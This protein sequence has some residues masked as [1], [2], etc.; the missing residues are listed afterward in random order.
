MFDHPAGVL[1][2]VFSVLAFHGSVYLLVALIAGWRFGYWITGAAT[3]ALLFILTAFW[4]ITALGPRGIEPHWVPVGAAQDSV[5]QVTVNDATLISTST[6]PGSTWESADSPDSPLNPE[7]DAFRSAV[8]N[9][10]DTDPDSL[11]ENQ[12]TVCA[13]AQALL[14]AEDTLPRADGLAVTVLKDVENI[15]FNEE[16][17]VLLATAQVRPMTKD[18]RVTD[19]T[20]DGM[21]LGE[22]FLITAF[23]DPGS[24]RWPAVKYFIG[25]VLLLAFHMWGLNRAEKRGTSHVA[26]TVSV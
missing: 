11:D 6:Y 8:G 7:Q 2:G 15:R 1:V 20:E 13:D 26:E 18:P 25:A 16:N 4:L 3:S 21:T 23:R 5:A 17:G 19:Q 24:L 10:L 9:C 22:P 12:Q 14:P